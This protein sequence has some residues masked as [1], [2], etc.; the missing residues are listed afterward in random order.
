MIA[1]KFELFYSFYDT[2]TKEF[3]KEVKFLLDGDRNVTELL[4]QFMCFM[5]ACGY[6]FNI[7]DTLQVVNED[8][9]W[10][11]A[12]AENVK[13]VN[14][15]ESNS[16]CDSDWS[17]PE[18]Y[19]PTLEDVPSDVGVIQEELSLVQEEQNNFFEYASTATFQPEDHIVVNTPDVKLQKI[20]E[21]IIPFLENLRKDPEKA[22]IRWPNR[23]QVVDEHIEKIMKI[24]GE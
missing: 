24:I 21:T 6:H 22:M 8:L 17:P 23:S 9:D 19:Y 1:E 10:E 11:R 3:N 20:Q 7:S 13:N 2:E 12:V 15:S 16:D 4:E 14:A 18:W 5:K